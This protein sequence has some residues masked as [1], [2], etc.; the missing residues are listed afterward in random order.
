MTAEDRV[1]NRVIVQER[2]SPSERQ[3]VDHASFD[4][5]PLI[6]VGVAVIGVSVMGI[7]IR[8]RAT[9]ASPSGGVLIIQEVRPGVVCIEA[10]A[11]TKAPLNFR[12]ECVV[13]GDCVVSA[14]V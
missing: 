8:L 5:V 14:A 1:Q 4:G 11:V 10:Q 9:P 6:E 13:V 2:F 7:L 12:L 3:I